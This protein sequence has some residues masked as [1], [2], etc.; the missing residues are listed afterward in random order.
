VPAVGLVAGGDVLAERDVGVTL[1]GDVVVVVDQ[2]E[3]A[4]LLV[5]GDRGRLAADPFLEVAVAADGVD[6][7]V[8]RALP[9]GRVGVEQ[10]ALAAGGHRHADRVG[11]TLA[12]RTG[13]GLDA[14]GV[15]ELG[16]ARSLAAPGAQRLEVVDLEPE[17]GEVELGVQGDAGVAAGQHEPVPPGPVRVGRIVSHHL[18]EQHVGD[19]R[20]AHRRTGVAVADLLHRVHRQHAGGVHRTP[21]DVGPFECGGPCVAHERAFLST[22]VQ[23]PGAAGGLCRGLQRAGRPRPEPTQPG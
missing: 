7:V 6:V 22:V 23:R 9:L 1:D 4:E 11:D 16:V 17:A 19:R 18:L 12:E 3:V 10:A 14:G 5:T 13:G 20:E 2:G 15:P 8:E 21:V